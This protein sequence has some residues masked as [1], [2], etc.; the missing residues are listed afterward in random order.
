V[1][2]R[3]GVSRVV[4][5]RYGGEWPRARFR[6]HGVAYEPSPRAKSDIYLDLLP[7]LNARRVELLDIPRLSA[8]L[9]G[10]ER[11]TA[12]SG[13]DSV[14][15]IP[16]MTIWRTASRECWSGSIWIAARR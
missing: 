5:D 8:Q 10:L 15:H 2:R 9:C 12:R 6:E 3:F 4:G 13:R 11:R 14:D 7:L 1:L 16:A